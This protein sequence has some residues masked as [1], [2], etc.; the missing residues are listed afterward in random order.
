MST[1]T[2]SPPEVQEIPTYWFALMEAAKDRGDFEQAA[3]AKRELERL[4]V[5]VSYRPRRPRKGGGDHA[6]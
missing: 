2:S 6:T 4:G 3:H 5:R 1:A